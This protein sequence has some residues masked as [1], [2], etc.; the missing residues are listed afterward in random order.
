MPADQRK[1][2]AINLRMSPAVKGL[3]RA[4]AERDHRTLSNL[5]EV[6]ILEHCQKLGI[7]AQPEAPV[8][9]KKRAKHRGESA[10]ARRG[11]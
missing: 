3:L 8:A 2:E 1:T 4:A 11:T 6:L 7:E 10:V 9:S 5:M